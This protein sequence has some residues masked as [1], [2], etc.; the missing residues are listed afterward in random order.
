MID[1]GVEVGN[2]DIPLGVTIG[3]RFGRAGERQKINEKMVYQSGEI[4]NIGFIVDIGIH[5]A[6]RS[7]TTGGGRPAERLGH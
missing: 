1:E 4:G 3:V 6:G 5:I 7:H 2:V